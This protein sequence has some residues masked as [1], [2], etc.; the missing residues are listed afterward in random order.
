MIIGDRIYTD[1]GT[2]SFVVI[3]KVFEEILLASFILLLIDDII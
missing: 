2:F 1:S 3:I